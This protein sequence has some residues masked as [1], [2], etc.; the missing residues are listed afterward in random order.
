[1]DQSTH[2]QATLAQQ[3]INA[4][5]AMG[6][7]LAGI[8]P[9]APS[10]RAAEFR[11]WLAEGQHGD[12]DYMAEAIEERLNIQALLPGAKSIILV[13]DQYAP[14]ASGTATLRVASFD[15]ASDATRSV[16][17]PGPTGKIA[18]YARG[19]DYH[20]VIRRRLHNLADTLR[21]LPATKGLHYQTFV[22]TAPVLERE[23]AARANMRTSDGSGGAFVGKHT[24]LIHPTL[25]SYL[26]LGGI[27]TTLDLAAP[28]F[29][30]VSNLKSEISNLNSPCGSCT[31]CIDACPT[32]AITPNHINA[33]RCISYLTLEHRD[34]IAPEFHAPIADH[35]LG[36]DICQDV[37]PFNAPREGDHPQAHLYPAYADDQHRAHLPLLEV[38][39]WTE[40]DRTRVLS[41]SAAKR[42]SL[43]MLKRNAIIAAANSLASHPNS[44]L[45]STITRL[46]AD[47]NE[48]P[49]V[50]DT[51]KQVLT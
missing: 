23:H 5:H 8:A 19:R 33:T 31:R 4:C 25:G 3:V 45:H 30:S 46:A 50:R 38:L 51:A 9:A 18:K 28:D 13:A 37:C 1:V 44:E 47:P 49:L 7:A 11:A 40:A 32:K 16:A 15:D 17:V 41:T 34:L 39:N 43:P 20:T 22:D 42:A 12:M 24:L 21:T 48:P 35:L 29:D 10:S 2:D 26:L 27:V 14:R 36:C 6:F